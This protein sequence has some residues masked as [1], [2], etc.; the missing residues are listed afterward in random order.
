MSPLDATHALKTF[1]KVMEEAQDLATAVQL[2]KCLTMRYSMPGELL[3][4]MDEELLDVDRQ[5]RA[6][7]F[8][9]APVLRQRLERL[10][11]E[12]RGGM[13]H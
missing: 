6:R 11:H 7:L 12:L 13:A 4:V 9:V 2:A 1:L 3:G 8:A 10:R 5:K